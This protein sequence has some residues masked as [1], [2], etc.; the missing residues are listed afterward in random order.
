MHQ[1]LMPLDM[2]GIVKVL[3]RCNN[4]QLQ[5]TESEFDLLRRKKLR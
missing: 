4:T 5:G 1:L 3:N 2:F